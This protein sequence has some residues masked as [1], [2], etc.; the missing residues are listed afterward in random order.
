[1]VVLAVF[2]FSFPGSFCF[3]STFRSGFHM[4][5]SVWLSG[6]SFG[7]RR[8][9]RS[10]STLVYMLMILFTEKNQFDQ[11]SGERERA[12]SYF[13]RG[14]MR[15][16]PNGSLTYLCLILIDYLLIGRIHLSRSHVEGEYARCK[17]SDSFLA[18]CNI[19]L[20]QPSLTVLY[21][22]KFN[23]R[24]HDHFKLGRSF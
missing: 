7:S 8:N 23:E 9:F 24:Y 2:F 5:E 4:N 14:E 20:F 16:V 19:T 13:N 12:R 18:N 6:I 17:W 15:N 3:P 22:R 11:N 10:G 21:Y 1:M